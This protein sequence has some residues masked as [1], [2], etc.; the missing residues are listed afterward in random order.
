MDQ[1]E[2]LNFIQWCNQHGH[3][4]NVAFS[5][6]G[7]G[8]GRLVV[9]PDPNKN[10]IAI[11]FKPYQGPKVNLAIDYIV[12]RL[13]Y[14]LEKS[15]MKELLIKYGSHT[16]QANNPLS[17]SQTRS[18][19]HANNL[20][21]VNSEL[22]DRINKHHPLVLGSKQ[23]DLMRFLREIG[24]EVLGLEW[25]QKLRDDI[26]EL[27]PHGISKRSSKIRLLCGNI[28]KLVSDALTEWWSQIDTREDSEV[29]AHIFKIYGLKFDK[30]Q[31]DKLV[32]KL[33]S[34]SYS[35]NVDFG[36]ALWDFYDN[37]FDSLLELPSGV[38]GPSVVAYAAGLLCNQGRDNA[39]CLRVL[40]ACSRS[41]SLEFKPLVSFLQFLA[42]EPL[43]LSGRM[44]FSELD[45]TD[46]FLAACY[47]PEDK[48]ASGQLRNITRW[49]LESIRNHLDEYSL[50]DFMVRGVQPR[51]AELAF[52]QIQKRIGGEG[53]AG[54]IDLNRQVVEAMALRIA[55][56]KNLPDAD[57][58]DCCGA[59]FDVK[60]NLYFR[61]KSGHEGLRGFAIKRPEDG[62][63]T[64]SGIVFFSTSEFDCEWAY[65]GNFSRESYQGNHSSQ[66]ERF[67]MDQA[68]RIL[69]FYF[70]M[71]K[72][73]RFSASVTP[74]EAR[75]SASLLVDERLKMAWAIAVNQ[76]CNAQ[77]NGLAN[78]LCF[79]N[80][81]F[82][83][84]RECG[85]QYPVEYHMWMGLTNATLNGCSI[86]K[87][88]DVGAMH[89]RVLAM[90][91]AGFFPVK[92]AQIKN[93]TL[94]EKWLECVLKPLA[95]SFGRICCPVCK[96]KRIVLKPGRVTAGG[97]IFGAISCQE[98]DLIGASEITIVTHCH[99]CGFYPLIIG[100]NNVCEMCHGLICTQQHEQD[101]CN[102]CKKSCIGKELI[103]SID[104]Q[105]PR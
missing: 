34:A 14:G 93:T 36:P 70:Q 61:S 105:S 22:R 92:L 39:D 59:R 91:R 29:L 32:K 58:E 35:C 11:G 77:A 64:Y 85:A 81:L 24:A 7:Y 51:V 71:P 104:N 5:H 3:L 25:A 94:L 101:Q 1:T 99:K 44:Q 42:M 56:T 50:N 16:N 53:D 80:L 90:L 88:D 47:Y 65:I 38:I 84:I 45:E 79:D 40:D 98:C 31:T 102:A 73:L 33:A 26:K 19:T 9:D 54:M 96:G 68:I 86:G 46:L 60:S 89:E 30:V 72:T 8:R 55:P 23:E 67:G 66:I 15:V 12:S 17:I 18:S 41:E 28:E 87:S 4:D 48:L 75:C 74:D 95:K 37:A 63:A 10:A 97:T 43:S 27:H 78:D 2:K 103:G 20:R 76:G 6:L 57:W 62:R 83:A 100:Q 82:E 21:D 52:A 13:P 49:S 69:P